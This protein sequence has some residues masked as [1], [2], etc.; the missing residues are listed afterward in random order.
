MVTPPRLTRPVRC[1]LCALILPHG[2]LRLLN[3]PNSAALLHH[4]GARHPGACRPYLTR[5]EGVVNLLPVDMINA[6]AGT[7][8]P[9]S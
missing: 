3:K 2:W 5:M 6:H 9:G 1:T 8:W 7:R 4:L